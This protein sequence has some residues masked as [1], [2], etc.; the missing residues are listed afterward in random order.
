MG[1]IR[2]RPI[3]KTIIRGN[4]SLN[5]DTFETIVVS[6]EFYSTKGEQLIVIRDVDHCKI[7]LD[8]TTTDKIRIKTLTNCM[9]TPDMGRI[10]D[11]WDEISVG[12]GACVELQNV[13]GV[14]YILSSDGLKM[15]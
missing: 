12:R 8:S 11:D 15:E 10:D 5:L 7:K 14:W 4:R 13:R 1:V 2:E 6:E 3:R 9:I